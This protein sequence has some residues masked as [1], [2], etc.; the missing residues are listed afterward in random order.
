MEIEPHGSEFF[1]GSPLALVSRGTIGPM[2]SNYFSIQLGLAGDDEVQP[3]ELELA[4]T[5]LVTESGELEELR[6]FIHEFKVHT[7]HKG[8]GPDNNPYIYR[9]FHNRQKKFMQS[10]QFLIRPQFCKNTGAT[11]ALF[12]AKIR[13]LYG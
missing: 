1:W 6:G 7:P 12:F 5:I 2:I 13:Q 10:T 4:G 11:R 3:Y 8:S 9:L